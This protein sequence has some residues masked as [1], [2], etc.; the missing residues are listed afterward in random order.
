[1]TIEEHKFISNI[2]PNDIIEY[3]LTPYVKFACLF[4]DFDCYDHS[5]IRKYTIIF[6]ESNK[7]YI[8][9]FNE[10]FDIRNQY[11]NV[12]NFGEEEYEYYNYEIDITFPKQKYN[13]YHFVDGEIKFLKSFD[14]FK[15]TKKYCKTFYF[16]KNGISPF[17][18]KRFYFN[19]IREDVM[20]PTEFLI[21]S[22][23]R[24]TKCYSLSKL[25]RWRTIKKID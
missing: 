2:V 5:E 9:E 20:L 7:Y 1:M 4:H 19:D 24:K 16:S 12:L 18:K 17:V 21:V 8:E 22:N 11:N 23:V 6:S 25:S 15:E 14:I 13:I 10:Y 3:V